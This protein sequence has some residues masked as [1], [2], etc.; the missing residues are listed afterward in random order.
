MGIIKTQKVEL[1]VKSVRGEFLRGVD[2]WDEEGKLL[3][4]RF[5]KY[6]PY[7]LVISYKRFV[8]S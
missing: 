1:R 7:L 3:D 2:V 6:P 4:Y 8:V 5:K